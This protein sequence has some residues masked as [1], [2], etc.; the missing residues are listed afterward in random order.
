MQSTP[1][2]TSYFAI[3][4]VESALLSPNPNYCFWWASG[5]SG[6]KWSMFNGSGSGYDISWFE[7]NPNT[8]KFYME[9]IGGG[10]HKIY[11]ATKAQIRAVQNG[12]SSSVNIGSVFTL[13]A[14]TTPW[15][16]SSYIMAPR[17][18]GQSLWQAASN[19]G[20]TYVSTD[21]INWTLSTTFWTTQGLPSSTTIFSGL[22]S[23]SYIYAGSGVANINRFSS[24][25]SSVSQN[26]LVENQTTFGN[27]QRSGLVLSAGDKLYCQNYGTAA[28]SIYVMGYEG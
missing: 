23:T 12:N 14:G 1:Y 19:N 28:Y 22:T 4:D 7:W 10:N 16:S 5:A 13:E 9:Y 27:Y 6:A 20:N 17:R 18:I 21:L 11:S 3:G 25:F 24:G 8:Q 15:T 26:A 2:S